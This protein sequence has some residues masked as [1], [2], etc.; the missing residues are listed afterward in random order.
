MAKNRRRPEFAGAIS[1]LFVP[2]E[3]QLLIGQDSEKADG[4]CQRFVKT[5]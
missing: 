4:N 2:K 3:N 5:M 1:G